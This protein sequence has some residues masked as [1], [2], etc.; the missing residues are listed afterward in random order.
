M[1]EADYISQPGNAVYPELT[2]DVNE[3]VANVSG[4][5]NR[6]LADSDEHQWLLKQS[7]YTHFQSLITISNLGLTAGRILDVGAG[8][9]ALTLDLGWL[10][11]NK[12][13]ITAVDN[14]PTGLEILSKMA[15][16][17]GISIRT[18]LGN[19]YDLPV[20]SSTQ[21]LTVARLLLQHLDRPVAALGEMARV[22]RPGG[23]VLVMDIDDEIS[24]SDP[25]SAAAFQNLRNAVR[26]LQGL[27]GGDRKIGHKLYRYMKEAGLED[28]QVVLVP[29]MRL[30]NQSG[31]DPVAEAYQVDRFMSKK[32]DLLV[33]GLISEEAFNAGIEE[34]KASFAED[35]FELEAQFVVVGNVPG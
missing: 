3:W 6:H 32:D 31:R 10:Q 18:K 15:D 1:Q 5:I 21:D 11:R 25:P 27:Y 8:T 17:L 13:E 20:E 26:E 19:A 14:D 29:A 4:A 12:G 33:A 35:R 7:N 24:V 9:G 28:I 22:T 16:E 30:G 2:T 34:L 23:K